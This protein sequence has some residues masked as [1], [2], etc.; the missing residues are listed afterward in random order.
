M[1]FLPF[2]RGSCR[3]IIFV[4]YHKNDKVKKKL[5]LC[6]EEFR[7]QGCA[8]TN[9]TRSMYVIICL[10]KFEMGYNYQYC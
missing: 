3:N 2:D 1:S 5:F 4:R 6:L 9:Y 10:F 7:T 8:L